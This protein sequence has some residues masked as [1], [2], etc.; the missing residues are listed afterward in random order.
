MLRH[1]RLLKYREIQE[2][3]RKSGVLEELESKF[4]NRMEEVA[5]VI[6]A[7]DIF[8]SGRT[9]P[10][11]DQGLKLYFSNEMMRKG[12]LEVGC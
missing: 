12:M 11:K 7:L 3:V 9:E 1:K 4:P 5:L 10:I 6:C 2:A 8:E